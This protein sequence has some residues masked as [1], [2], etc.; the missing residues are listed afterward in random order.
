MKRILLF[1]FFALF[2]AQI[3]AQTPSYSPLNGHSHN[4]YE[5]KQP[6]KTAFEAGLGSIEA[7][8]YLVNGNLFVAHNAPDIKEEKTLDALYLKPTVEAIRNGKAYPFLLLIDIKSDAE[9][10]LAEVVRQINRYPDVFNDS[11]LVKFVISGR[12][13][14]SSLW[15]TYPKYILFDGRPYETYTDEEWQHVGMVSDNFKNYT[16]PNH[17]GMNDPVVFSKLSDLVKTIHAK[18]KKVRL[19]DTSDDKAVWK[20]LM[21]L[22][23]DFINTDAPDA[24]KTFIN[25]TK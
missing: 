11:S 1:T 25:E 12:R 16:D 3:W 19:W 23:V 13:P 14:S 5:Q 10:T 17:K 22:G 18:G 2:F 6:F 4:D 24:L 20:I 7:D 21:Q 9:T 15:V 8:V